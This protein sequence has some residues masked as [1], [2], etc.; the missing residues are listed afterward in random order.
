MGGAA[1]ELVLVGE[2]CAQQFAEQDQLRPRI[3]AHSDKP[4]D[5]HSRRLSGAGPQRLRRTAPRRPCCPDRRDMLQPIPDRR[6]GRRWLPLGHGIQAPAG[7][8]GRD[9]AIAE[10]QAWLPLV[11]A[12]GAF[13]GLTAARV[14]ELWL[15]PV[16]ASLPLF[17][18]MGSV[19]GE[20]KPDR[21]RLLVSRHPCSP[22]SSIIEGLPVAPV[23]DAL[24]ACARWLGI[25]DLVVLIDSALHLRL[26]TIDD[27][28]RAAAPR[29][30]GAPALRAALAAADGRSESPWETLLRLLHLVLGVDVTPQVRI[31]DR[32]GG[33][34]ARADLLLDGTRT[35]H[36]YDGADHRTADQHRRDLDRDRRL[37]GADHVRRGYTSEVVLHRPVAV[38]RDC[39][40]ALGR[41]LPSAGL[42]TWNSLLATSLFTPAGSRAVH[43]R[44]AQACS[45]RE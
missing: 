25:L 40:L 21:T 33:F 3:P 8:E 36:E 45:S 6:R 37:V 20:V 12:S 19:R 35:V 41:R 24:L 32:T 5:V 2:V 43:R 1:A 13:T 22:P 16:P 30:K 34:V 18:A 28:K 27:V 38:L 14:H 7:L 4:P 11:P 42:Q 23:P 10:L 31:L 15:P 26:C 44:I 39:E 17:V 9:A 29:R